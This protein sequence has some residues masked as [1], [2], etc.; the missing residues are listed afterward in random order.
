MSARK[1]IRSVLLKL[2]SVLAEADS[3]TDRP[4]PLTLVEPR[5]AAD[6]P[7]LKKKLYEWLAKRF[8][9]HE[10]RTF[11]AFHYEDLAGALN[12]EGSRSEAAFAVVDAWNRHGRIN[13]TLVQQL[14]EARPHAASEIRVIFD[15]SG[16]A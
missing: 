10:L 1:I 5:F 15:G 14:I 7:V 16:S 11:V 9:V 3:R 2:A 8:S 6:D 4:Q 13:A 12:L